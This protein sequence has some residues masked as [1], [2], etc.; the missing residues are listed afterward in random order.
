MLEIG[1]S[2][3]SQQEFVPHIESESMSQ[4]VYPAKAGESKP[5]KPEKEKWPPELLAAAA[6][7]IIAL[8]ARNRTSGSY[9]PSGSDVGIAAALTVVVAT[10]LR[11]WLYKLSRALQFFVT[12]A[13]TLA[14]VLGT[15]VAANL[16]D[17]APGR[18]ARRQAASWT[19]V[20]IPA[21]LLGKRISAGVT[22]YGTGYGIDTG[23]YID[24]HV[25]STISN[26]ISWIPTA[27]AGPR[28]YAEIE[29]RQLSGSAATACVLTFAYRSL[30]SFFQLALRTDALQLAYW[31]G[32]IPARAYD[33]PVNLPFAANLQNWHR[34]AVLVNESHLTAFVDDRRIFS[35]YI[36][37]PLTGR[38]TFGT[39]DIG[40]GYTDDATCQFRN[41]KVRAGR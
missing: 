24:I 40:S 15:G 33:G 37:R 39:L 26:L 27:S 18:D 23:K 25:D 6:T 19:S 14:V 9:L 8:F 31:D 2:P 17:T 21:E 13:V 10:I 36:D 20:V 3:V 32:K 22:K 11:R 28:Y 35:E 38:V 5:D 29:A 16:F 4:Q 12:L 30:D 1:I 41:E 34:I 7:I